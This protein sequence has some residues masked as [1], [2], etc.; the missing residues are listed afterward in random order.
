MTVDF[1][2]PEVSADEGD[3]VR[4]CVVLDGA[5]D[6]EV[7]VNITTVDIGSASGERN[8]NMCTLEP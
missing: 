6:R 5:I 3:T 1:L 7:V 4:V 8:M 2:E